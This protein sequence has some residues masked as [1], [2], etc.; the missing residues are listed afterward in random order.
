M[1]STDLINAIRA[2]QCYFTTAEMAQSAT[3]YPNLHFQGQACC[4]YNGECIHSSQ[5]SFL[6]D[7]T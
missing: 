6:K 7:S 3:L 5:R 2:G 1:T 4:Y